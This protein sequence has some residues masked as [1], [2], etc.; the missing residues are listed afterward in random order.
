MILKE[1]ALVQLGSSQGVVIPKGWIEIMEIHS[2]VVLS[3]EPQSMTI[4]IKK[5]E[6]DKKEDS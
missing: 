2:L 4:T 5:S 1:K 3:F 6:N